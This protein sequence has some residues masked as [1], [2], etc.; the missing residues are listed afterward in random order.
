VAIYVAAATRTYAGTSTPQL[1]SH[2]A[3]TSF[4]VPP[5]TRFS[6]SPLSFQVTPARLTSDASENTTKKAVKQRRTVIGVAQGEDVAT[7]EQR[8]VL[9]AW[10]GDDVYE[11]RSIKVSRSP[12]PAKRPILSDSFNPAAR[13]RD[14][15]TRIPPAIRKL[16]G[17]RRNGARRL[18]ILPR[19][20]FHRFRL[21]I[22]RLSYT[23]PRTQIL[24]R[25]VTAVGRPCER[26]DSVMQ[27]IACG[28]GT[29]VA[30]GF[31]GDRRLTGVGQG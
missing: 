3:T 21:D 16:L 31:G 29:T 19:T 1:S 15:S 10:D 28:P 17:R 7:T 4:T 26:N 18:P 12:I 23:T 24:T 20:Y 22:S 2:R 25:S 13:P 30:G 11:K 27:G 6:C 8:R 14:R 5:S 9:W